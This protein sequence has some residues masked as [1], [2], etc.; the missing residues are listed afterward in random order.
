MA[1]VLLRQAVFLIKAQEV[2]PESNSPR[3]ETKYPTWEIPVISGRPGLASCAKRGSG[4]KQHDR[5]DTGSE[6]LYRTMDMEMTL[7][8]DFLEYQAESSLVKTRSFK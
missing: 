3:S 6:I 2:L 4:H 1:A 5:N 7:G 8:N